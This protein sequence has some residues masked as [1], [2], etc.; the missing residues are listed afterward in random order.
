MLSSTA[1]VAGDVAVFSLSAAAIVVA[2]CVVAL[3]A[4]LATYGVARL[5]AGQRDTFSQSAQ[6]FDEGAV[7]ENFK[8]WAF[9]LALSARLLVAR[10]AAAASSAATA[11][12]NNWP[13]LAAFLVAFPVALLIDT[14]HP[15]LLEAWKTLNNCFIAPVVRPIFLPVVNII[16]LA[17]SFI[18]PVTNY[19]FVQLQRTAVLYGVNDVLACGTQ[20]ARTFLEAL[21]GAF[22]E[23]AKAISLWLAGE[24]GPRIS[25]T[26][27]F[28][29]YAGNLGDAINAGQA[30][31]VCSCATLSVLTE[32]LFR[33]FT[34]QSRFPQAV[35][36]TAAFP[37]V[38][39]QAFAGPL[40]RAVEEFDEQ[41]GAVNGAVLEAFRPSANATID[42][43]GDFV[44]NWLL[45]ADGVWQNYYEDITS[46]LEQALLETAA[47]QEERKFVLQN[48]FFPPPPKRF[49][50]IAYDAT[51]VGVTAFL[52]IPLNA[53][54]NVDKV[55][56]TF[57]GQLF[58]R[59]D[60][61]F[62]HVNQVFV[63]LCDLVRFLG[64]FI[65]GVVAF[66]FEPLSGPGGSIPTCDGVRSIEDI[67]AENIPCV[68]KLVGDVGEALCETARQSTN[69]VLRIVKNVQELVIGTVYTFGARASEAAQFPEPGQGPCQGGAS[70]DPKLV[71]YCQV[72]RTNTTIFDYWQ[73]YWGDREDAS[74][75]SAMPATNE[76]RVTLSVSL[77]AV[78]EL[79]KTP[80]IFCGQFCA[81]WSCALTRIWR[82]V[83]DAVFIFIDVVVH[84]VDIFT[85]P[86]TVAFPSI[87]QFL[88]DVDLLGKCAEL[89]FPE[90]LYNPQDS[91]NFFTCIVRLIE[92]LAKAFVDV[93]TVFLDLIG[94]LYRAVAQDS[95]PDFEA[96]VDKAAVDVQVVV[97][98][99]N[100]AT[101]DTIC[102]LTSTIPRDDTCPAAGN[103]R[104]VRNVVTR[105]LT[106]P[107]QYFVIIANGAVELTAGVIETGV[108]V[109]SSQRVDQGIERSVRAVVQTL[110]S[111]VEATFTEIGDLSSCFV[112]ES[113]GEAF[114][115]INTVLQSLVE[116]LVDFISQVFLCV[117]YFVFGFLEAVVTVF[118]GDPQITL[119]IKAFECLAEIV[120]ELVLEILPRDFACFIES[121]ICILFPDTETCRI[122]GESISPK[123][124]ENDTMTRI[125][126][127]ISNFLCGI[128]LETHILSQC[129][130]RCTPVP[131]FCVI[132]NLICIVDT[133][134]VLGITFGPQVFS[135]NDRCCQN[136]GTLMCNCWD[137][138]SS[139][140]LE[141]RGCENFDEPSSC[142]SKKRNTPGSE[143]GPWDLQRS[144]PPTVGEV[145][146]EVFTARGG[147]GAY[148]GSQFSC[149]DTL[150]PYANHFWPPLLG[151]SL[152]GENK[153]QVL[154]PPENWTVP[155]LLDMCVQMYMVPG[156]KRLANPAEFTPVPEQTFTA[157]LTHAT[158]TGLRAFRGAVSGGGAE[159]FA[160]G[161][162][163]RPEGMTT[164]PSAD[165]LARSLQ[166]NF[167]STFAALKKERVFFAAFPEVQ[168]RQGKKRLEAA[169]KIAAGLVKIGGIVAKT[170]AA[171]GP[172][173]SAA[174]PAGGNAQFS[175]GGLVSLFEHVLRGDQGPQF[176]RSSAKNASFHGNAASPLQEAVRAA[177]RVSGIPRSLRAALSQRRVAW[178]ERAKENF[179]ARFDGSLAR[180]RAKRQTPPE[181][182]Q[183]ESLFST[184]TCPPE[185]TLCFNC[186][187]L[188]RLIFDGGVAFRQAERYYGNQS[189]VILRD[190]RENTRTTL[191]DPLGNDTYF[192]DPKTVPF[193]LNR[194]SS[195]QWPWL[196]SFTQ[197]FTT[198][199][200]NGTAFPGG[201]IPADNNFTDTVV[202]LQEK[203]AR[204]VGRNDTD[205]F[206]IRTVPDSVSQFTVTFAERGAYLVSE[207][208]S[209]GA[210]SVVAR[211]IERYVICDYENVLSCSGPTSY[212]LGVFDGFL[213]ATLAL[214]FAAPF[215]LV[216]FF[217]ACGPGW[218]CAL[219][220]GALVW[221]PL[222]MTLAF[223]GS[224]LCFLPSVVSPVPG[225]P[226]CFPGQVYE[227]L[228]ETFPPGAELPIPLLD[229]N[230][231]ATQNTYSLCL[232][233]TPR[234]A[235]CAERAGFID[236]FDNIFYTLEQLFPGT[237]E[238]L[239]S[240][241]FLQSLCP[242]LASLAL[243]Y[244]AE[245][246]AASGQG[247]AMAVCNRI[248][249]LNI[250]GALAVVVVAAAAGAFFVF[251]LVAF[252]QVL[253][254]FVL[255]TAYTIHEM[256]VQI[257]CGFVHGQRAQNGE[258]KVKQQ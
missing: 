91:N 125:I 31:V 23:F 236:G 98:L 88:L 3:L 138:G 215:A 80:E 245:G 10:T 249:F 250:F 204:E 87:Q 240:S 16:S 162:S 48:S 52:K 81:S 241:S 258:K 163:D 34:A 50:A 186:S 47:T 194:L 157:Y 93:A 51:W 142:S 129:G 237:N 155:A 133:L 209:G 203:R 65:R 153:S 89:V 126:C 122:A 136:S 148:E 29:A 213:L 197:F 124:R 60:E 62:G 156:Q 77:E 25:V 22:F 208:F 182:V 71:S 97:R 120:L 211:F 83:L 9:A 72:P 160:S 33:S 1:S 187:T 55:F 139:G 118:S 180:A 32:P 243:R 226:S 183:G 109:A 54:F 179:F 193:I 8:D 190:F 96:T 90:P 14:Y 167:P 175:F 128:G 161:A 86:A 41:G 210:N 85:K 18:L 150:R 251:L 238:Q 49:F 61:P 27:D 234:V 100:N 123:C 113:L 112:D 200:P 11:V 53:L 79:A 13:A 134:E 246:I 188:D 106:L 217:P 104:P 42:T 140:V 144:L 4:A 181:V 103:S 36:A 110:F 172:L 17:A 5:Y 152:H 252:F 199:D 253:A 233:P 116:P 114:A 170:N 244:T 242:D 149:L 119:L 165:K 201:A 21:A 12:V 38:F 255:A 68:F 94:G 135:A 176:V 189:S 164:H 146:P 206:W 218:L 115:E 202:P 26:P 73:F 2:F 121:G 84:F 35:N 105:A 141:G 102:L 101:F 198:I 212:G 174:S 216:C 43:A 159:N 154:A 231:P 177:V 195:V 78:T 15:E 67:T 223:A 151:V 145:F 191:V 37:V 192:T 173:G 44:E 99:L 70:N 59:L 132:N 158:V 171:V 20:A 64:E 225:V 205:L 214:F 28:T 220:L 117:L 254:T 137:Y 108:E 58:W 235:S 178:W 6:C 228:S 239:A 127:D 56:K 19:F 76:F 40:V 196:W 131:E 230:D 107:S 221:Y 185:Q 257:D 147:S 92:L 30:F 143:N 229:E 66:F 219:V 69:F 169:K 247:A 82:L 63:G 46:A 24:A 207:P 130:S 45:V 224:P 232:S 256:A 74:L 222:G 57:D 168:A 95:V 248:L 111:L 227:I 184:F 75:P 39:A 166:A 7:L